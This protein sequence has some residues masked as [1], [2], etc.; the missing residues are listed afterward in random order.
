MI[1]VRCEDAMLFELPGL[2][3]EFF[4]GEGG[5]ISLPEGSVVLYGSLCHLAV[6]GLDNYADE[7]DRTGKTIGSMVGGRGVTTAHNIFVPLGGICS[8]GLIRMMLD[9]DCWLQV[10]DTMTPY[11]LT[12]SRNKL[13]ELL[14]EDGNNSY[15]GGGTGDEGTYYSICW[16]TLPPTGRSDSSLQHLLWNSPPS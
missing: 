15:I 11:S 12:R 3:R 16:R 8:A 7:V 5:R 13:W 4:A 9:L 6:R 14:L 2:L 10:G 1:V